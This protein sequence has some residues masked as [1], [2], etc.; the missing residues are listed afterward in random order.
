MT[1]C[2][3][4]RIFVDYAV[5]MKVIR[6]SLFAMLVFLLASNTPEQEARVSIHTEYGDIILKL[7]E[8]T[9]LHREN[10]LK[11]AEEGYFDSTLFHR[12]IQR[13]MIQGGD[14]DSRHAKAG[15]LLGDGGPAY[16]IPME[17][18]PEYI[19]KR[20]VIAMAR[21]GDDKNPKMESSGSQ[22]YIVQGKVFTDEMLDTL[23]RKIARQHNGA[24][25]PV[26]T[27]EQRAIYK[28]L[29]GTPHLDM[30]YT[31]FGEVIRGMEVVD[32]IAAMQT[33]TNDRPVKD[34]RM[35]IR[36]LK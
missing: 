13:F 21:E 1:G 12:V 18:V 36:V 33:D 5:P 23:Y 22:F 17:Y 10:F 27:A 3:T 9:P 14:P 35:T 6:F 30:F 16:T 2:E 19:H 28:T 25:G 31:P 7:Y 34:I 26:Y 32:K 24:K 15:Q 4:I 8:K 11:L 20:G 29:G